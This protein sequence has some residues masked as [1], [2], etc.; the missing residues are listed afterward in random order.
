MNSI[1]EKNLTQ[2]R[3]LI[4][5]NELKKA[6]QYL[7]RFVSSGEDHPNVYFELGNLYHLRGEIGR[8]IKSFKKTLEIDPSHTDASISL[9]VLLNDVGNIMLPE[10]YSRILIDE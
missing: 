9:S 8:A 7:S 1:V 10:K 3:A 6:E 5:T 2:V 4:K